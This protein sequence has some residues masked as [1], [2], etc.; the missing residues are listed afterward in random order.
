MIVPMQKVLIL[1][2]HRSLVEF[3]SELKRLGMVHV[4]VP[5]EKEDIQLN[6]KVKRVRAVET[7]LKKMKRPYG[8]K[9]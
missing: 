4:D 6:E 8:M 3:L 1:V 5:Y 7:V 2:Y 9:D